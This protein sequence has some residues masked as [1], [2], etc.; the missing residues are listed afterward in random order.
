MLT[1]ATGVFKFVKI[2]W[3]LLYQ[4]VIYDSNSDR[5]ENFD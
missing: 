5:G 1:V 3:L 2:D 4:G